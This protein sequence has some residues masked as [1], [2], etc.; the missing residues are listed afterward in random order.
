MIDSAQLAQSDG[1]PKIALAGASTSRTALQIRST[2]PNAHQKFAYVDGR[3]EPIVLHRFALAG[4]GDTIRVSRGLDQH[5]WADGD[6][7]IPISPIF[8]SF[9]MLDFVGRRVEMRVSEV[10]T[11][12][13]L[14]EQQALEAFHYRG[15]DFSASGQSGK[16]RRGVGGRRSVLVL[17]LRLDG[18][19]RTAGY[20]ELQ[21]PLM[22]AKPRHVAFQRPF[23]HA[24]F[25]VAWESWRMGGKTLVN[26]IAR[27]ARVVVHPELRGGGL[28]K[29]LVD[30]AVKYARE[31][32]HI[33]GKRPLFLEISAE[34]LRHIDFVSACGFHYLGDTEGNKSRLVKDMASMKQGPAGGSGIMSLQRRYYALFE[35]Y[36]ETTGE[37]FESLQGRLLQVLATTDTWDTMSVDEWLAFRPVVRSPIPYYMIGLDEIADGYVKAAARPKANDHPFVREGASD[38]R[39]ANLNVKSEYEP[40]HT[41]HSRLVMDAF[42]L[43]VRTLKSHVLGP[44]SLHAAAG[45]V[46]FVAGPSGSGKSMLL[47]ALDEGRWPRGVTIE[48]QIDPPSLDVGWLADLPEDQ[49]LFDYLASKHGPERAFDG[50]SRV[51]LSEALLFLKPYAMLSRGQRYRAKLAD[52]MLTDRDVWLIDEFCSDLDP[53]AARLV[54]YRLRQTVRRTGRVAFVAAANHRHFIEALRP[55]QVVQIETGGAVSVVPGGEYIRGIRDKTW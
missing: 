5:V 33:G 14:A 24:A 43:T 50:L 55:A 18:D 35:R 9:G 45:T 6:T 42:G 41:A 38:V 37:S 49:P 26:R 23:S 16:A 3:K 19:W 53:L 10:S 21:M 17:Q 11:A 20:I 4:A 44:V 2:R 15:L 40:T 54:A 36:R 22:M 52:L 27:I 48:G 25:G 32:W 1:R 30:A 12:K 8:E 31:R 47:T 51:G 34:M 39:L 46:T 29:P 28:S 7:P 13:E